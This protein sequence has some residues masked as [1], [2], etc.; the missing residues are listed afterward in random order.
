MQRGV[1]WQRFCKQIGGEGWGEG[2][3]LARCLLRKPPH[4]A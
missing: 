3:V 2:A 1:T 4:P